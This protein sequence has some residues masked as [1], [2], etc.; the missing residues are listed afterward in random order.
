MTTKIKRAVKDVCEIMRELEM[1]LVRIYVLFH[2]FKSLFH[3]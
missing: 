3:N 2:L 1:P